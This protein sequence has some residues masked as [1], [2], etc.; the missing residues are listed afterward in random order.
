MNCYGHELQSTSLKRK[1]RREV[2][3]SKPL[4]YF[5]SWTTYGTWLPGDDRGWVEGGTPG[6]QPPDPVRREDAAERMTHVVVVLT[7][8]QR[9]LVEVTIRKHCEIRR[10]HLHAVNARTNHI[11]VVVTADVAPE[12]V[13]SQLKA[14]CSRRLSEQSGLAARKRERR[15]G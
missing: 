2:P 1:R 4:A 9:Q 13:M 11:H 3:M 14:W 8:Q 12:V 7:P 5:I 15:T 6:I 10:W